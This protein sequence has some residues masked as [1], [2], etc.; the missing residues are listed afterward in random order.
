MESGEKKGIGDNYLKDCRRAA[1]GAKDLF[2]RYPSIELQVAG[3]IFF[4][5]AEGEK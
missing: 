1:A 5:E 4:Y 2:G 3:F